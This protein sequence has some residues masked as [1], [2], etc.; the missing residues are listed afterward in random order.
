MA[1]PSQI[2]F[3]LRNCYEADNREATL[4][5]IFG[6]SVRHRIVLSGRDELLTGLFPRVV[7]DSEKG[8]KAQRAAQVSGREH[9]LVVGAFF[10]VGRPPARRD[11]PSR[12][13]TPLIFFPARLEEQ[14]SL[15]YLTVDFSR[16]RLNCPVLARPLDRV[17]ALQNRRE[18]VLQLAEIMFSTPAHHARR[19]AEQIFDLPAHDVHGVIHARGDQYRLAPEQVVEGE[20]GDRVRLAGPGRADDDSERRMGGRVENPL[21]R[22]AEYGRHAPRPG[23]AL[24]VDR[25]GFFGEENLERTGELVIRRHGPHLRENASR[26]RRVFQQSDGAG[27]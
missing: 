18:K 5:D 14:D 16:Q 13:C 20:R 4:F 1:T 27:R 24:G 22:P 19:R 21:L 2:L 8:R 26:L 12:I 9:T 11:L 3:Y 25:G 7:V 23:R 17:H 15:S 6:D 10:L